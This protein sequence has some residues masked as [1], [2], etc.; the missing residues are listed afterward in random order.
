MHV[1]CAVRTKLIAEIKME[2]F[3]FQSKKKVFSTNNV[4]LW[5]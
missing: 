1:S 5:C 2:V 4:S 3:M